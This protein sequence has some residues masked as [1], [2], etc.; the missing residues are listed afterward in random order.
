MTSKMVLFL[1]EE[2]FCDPLNCDRSAAHCRV[3]FI[4]AASGSLKNLFHCPRPRPRLSSRPSDD[5][6]GAETFGRTKDAREL[7][8]G[9]EKQQKPFNLTVVGSTPVRFLPFFLIL[10]IGVRAASVEHKTQESPI[11]CGYRACMAAAL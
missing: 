8:S 6:A 5:E 4:E 3:C 7:C 9:C 1:L 11:D 10:P 2:I